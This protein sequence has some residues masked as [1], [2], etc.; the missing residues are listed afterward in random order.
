MR[1]RSKETKIGLLENSKR[2][3]DSISFEEVIEIGME[4][5]DWGNGLT[6]PLT[7]RVRID[8]EYREGRDWEKENGAGV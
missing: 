3:L 1:D 4:I 7:K 6:E 2:L 8:I 5:Q